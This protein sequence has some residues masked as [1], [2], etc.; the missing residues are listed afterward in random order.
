MTVNQ[1]GEI[2][3]TRRAPE[4]PFGGFLELPGG[5]VILGETPR[6]AARRELLEETGI[7]ADA[8]M[9]IYCGC[10]RRDH[11]FNEY[12]LTFSDEAS[13]AAIRLQA[14]ET[15][16]AEWVS[17]QQFLTL[18]SGTGF[19]GAEPRVYA[20]YFTGVFTGCRVPRPAVRDPERR[21]CRMPELADLCDS[22]GRPTGRTA[23][24]GERIQP[25]TYRAIV[26]I[27]TLTSD[28]RLLMT[29][30]AP[31]KSFAGCWEITGGCAQAGETPLQAAIRELWEETGLLAHPGE[32]EDRGMRHERGVIFRYFLLRRDVRLSDIRLQKGETDAAELVTPQ[33]LHERWRAGKTIAQECRHISSVYPEISE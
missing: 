6:E 16:A 8:D 20:K 26:S 17:P 33:E 32:L 4:K 22:E 28:G 14:G 18:A 27:L 9:L 5:A 15:E 13:A 23:V 12:F 19:D 29:R 24:R 10:G 3:V 25:D 1:R 2:L 11:W 7:A 30:R 31:Q 21:E